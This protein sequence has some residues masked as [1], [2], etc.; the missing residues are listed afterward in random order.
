VLSLPPAFAVNLITLSGGAHVSASGVALAVLSG[1]LASGV[2]YVVWYAALRGLTATRAA[3]VQLAVPV[4]AA[5]GGVLFLS[6][7]IS[8]RLLLAGVVILGGVGLA[9]LGRSHTARTKT[10]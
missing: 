10:A 5:V 8:L 2:G 4:L 1:A 6:E 7:R 3:T 9:L